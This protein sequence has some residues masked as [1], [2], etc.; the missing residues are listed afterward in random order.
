LSKVVTYFMTVV[1]P[2]TY[3]GHDRL[4]ALC[5]QHDATIELVPVDLGRIF[6]VSGGLP[7][8]ERAPQRQAYRLVELARWKAF[9]QMPF[10]AQPKFGASG[11]DLAAR[12][13]LAALELDTRAALGFTGAVMRARWVEERDIADPATLAV[14]ATGAGLPAATMAARAD[15]AEIAARYAAGTQEAIDRQVF[16]TPW[17]VVDGEPFWGQDRLDFLARKLAQ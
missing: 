2:W 12:W 16:G 13:T 8:K 6:P 9:L 3:F 10:N 7:L 17:Y 5:A 11:A 15:A 14:C 4:V 1:S